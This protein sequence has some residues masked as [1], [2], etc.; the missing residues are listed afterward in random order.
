M[1]ILG[2]MGNLT[3]SVIGAAVLSALDPILTR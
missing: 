2:G 1:V 3:G